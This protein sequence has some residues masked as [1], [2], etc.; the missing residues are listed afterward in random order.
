MTRAIFLMLC[1]FAGTADAVTDTFIA[2]GTWTAP[3]GGAPGDPG[4][5]ARAVSVKMGK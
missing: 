1:L 2:S 5:V 4:Y 3:A